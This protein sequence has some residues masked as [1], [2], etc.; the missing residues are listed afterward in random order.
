MR[1][2]D[3]F[4][5]SQVEDALKNAR[6]LRNVDIR[7]ETRNG[8]VTLFG[9]VD[10]LAEK[11]AAADITS[12]VPGVVSVDNS[13]TVAIDNQLEDHEIADIIQEKLYADD[14]VDLHQISVTVK[15]GVAYLQGDAGSIGQEETAKEIAARVQSVKDVVSYIKVGRG[16]F[17]IDDAT[18]TNRV[19][20]ALSRSPHVSVRDVETQ[21]INGRVVLSGTV[22]TAE[23][24]EAVNRIVSQVPGVRDIENDLDCRHET[25]NVEYGL[26]N[27]I[28]NELGH[29]GLG[30]VK[31]FVVEGTA[32]LNGAVGTPDQKHRAE[33]IVSK[34][35]GVDAIMNDIQL[36]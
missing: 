21:T 15:G 29:N 32:F 11:W 7:I 26:T 20:T 31:C 18:L 5:Q 12:K 4:I 13:L 30:G 14:R 10:V 25:K 22:D 19:E 34:F 24:I 9:L 23:Q 28:R 8:E 6:M 36:S 3:A 17:N 27:A 1:N 33:E 16:D 2:D 35:D